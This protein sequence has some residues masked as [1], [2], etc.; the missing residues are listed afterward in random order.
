MGELEGI[1]VVAEQDGD[2]LSMGKSAQRARRTESQTR[3]RHE[4]SDVMHHDP[5]GSVD[6][7]IVTLCGRIT[8]LEPTVFF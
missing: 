1:V 7:S 3:G 6:S 8:R 2:L 5:E 4:L